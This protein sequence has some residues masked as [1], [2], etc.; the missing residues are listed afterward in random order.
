MSKPQGKPFIRIR[1]DASWEKG[2]NSNG[3]IESHIN[4]VHTADVEFNKETQVKVAQ[5]KLLD[6]IKVIYIPAIR[7]PNEQLKNVSGTI[8]YRLLNSIKW[9]EGMKSS[10][11]IKTAEVEDIF[12][13]E[14]PIKILTDS[15][16]KRLLRQ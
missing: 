14:P 5:K 8:M 2:I 7:Q 10:L 11:K 1:L 12:L 16:K 9:T 4:F 3:V 13:S 6:L 15:L